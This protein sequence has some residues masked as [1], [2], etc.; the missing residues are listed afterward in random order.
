M[1]SPVF[2][3]YRWIHKMTKYPTEICAKL[4][5]H[6][7]ISVQFNKSEI[8]TKLTYYYIINIHE[9]PITYSALHSSFH[10]QT[11]C[12]WMWQCIYIFFTYH[13]F[14]MCFFFLLFF[15]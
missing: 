4:L 2:E 10:K 5:Y 15:F 6:L 1:E 3:T 14:K 13:L 9:Q 12:R 8:T 11:T 7:Q